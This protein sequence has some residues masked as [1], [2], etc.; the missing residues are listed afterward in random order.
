[1]EKS[2]FEIFNSI[3][4]RSNDAIVCLD[5]N[6]RVIY[7]DKSAEIIFSIEESEI[8]GQNFYSI[9]S[10]SSKFS[11]RLKW[12]DN[13]LEKWFIK[14]FEA[15]GEK[16]AG[17]KFAVEFT[18][19]IIK[20]SDE[21]VLGK[22]AVIRD[23]THKKSIEREYEKTISGLSKL[24]E[25]GQHLHQAKSRVDLIKVIMFAVTSGKGLRFNRAFILSENKKTKRLEGIVGVGPS[26]Y[27]DAGRIWNEIS[28]T[29]DDVEI[30]M[31]QSLKTI[32]ERNIAVN[33]TVQKLSVSCTKEECILN[34]SLKDNK[35]Y[36][37]VDGKTDTDFDG[38]II[39]KLETD[40]FTVIP[41]KSE[42][43]KNYVLIVDNKFSRQNISESD[44]ELLEIFGSEVRL[45]LNNQKLN[46]KLKSKIVEL[47]KAYHT[48]SESQQRLL[49]SERLATLGEVV[50]DIS[51]EIRNPLVSIGGFARSLLKSMPENC[52]DKKYVKIILQ[53]AE[54]LEN[55]LK[56]ILDYSKIYKLH[57]KRIYISD[58]LQKSLNVFKQNLENKNINVSIE[59]EKPE[60]KISVDP[61]QI[62]Q[63]FINILRNSIDAMPEGGELSIKLE[64]L[65]KYM[66]IEITDSGVGIDDEK[67]MNLFRPFYTTKTDGIGLGLSICLK[68]IENHK[69]FI[70]VES[71]PGKG[72]SFKIGLP[73]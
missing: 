41:I 34:K 55:I 49:E 60:K 1:M 2:D 47:K 64:V 69:G 22:T 25:I 23:I 51:H 38:S 42:I 50:A 36:N 6:D 16:E 5:E 11:R 31:N 73:L 18:T 45:A 15:E 53:E 72:T 8:M 12:E 54:R 66:I 44:I 48:L 21:N 28:E 58:P 40:N 20:D 70:K 67:L 35:V 17:D 37:I 29:G 14:S 56:N 30:L 39:K 3:A 19:M 27:E 63:V 10:P 26:D 32:R 57:K 52:G 13:L 65:K 24:H 62:M 9:F 59:V 71:K 4:H 33:K 68:I 61:A 46:E 43:S 7:W